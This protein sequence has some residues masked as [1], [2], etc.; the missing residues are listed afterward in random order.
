MKLIALLFA[1]TL[2]SVAH[3]ESFDIFE[4]QYNGRTPTVTTQF[5]VNKQLG[6]AWVEINVDNSDADSSLGNDDYRTKVEGLRLDVASN[7]I[8]LE[9][10]GQLIECAKWKR[11]GFFG[12]S[13]YKPTGCKFSHRLIKKTVDDGFETYTVRAV[14]VTLMTLP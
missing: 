12:I 7:T 10:D 4:A 5:A 8:V 3:A 9:R 1:L 6:R 14:V 2:T 13:E 11:G